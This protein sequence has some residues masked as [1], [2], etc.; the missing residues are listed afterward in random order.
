MELE[1]RHLRTLCA[2]ADTGSLTKAATVLRLSQPAL[3]ARLKRVEAEIGAPLF[4]RGPRGVIATRLGEF[5]LV[6]AR[7]I[8][9]GVA[10]LN[11]GP[12][13]YADAT[14][15]VI[16]LG[17]ALGSVSVGL[18]ER[19]SAELS[20]VEVRLT[21]EYSPRLLWDLLVAGRL[22]AVATVDYPGYELVSTSDIQCARIAAEPVYVALAET[23]PLA[24]RAE[25]GLSELAER[26]WVM[27]P[28]DGAGWPDC[29]HHACERAGFT[30][31]VLYTSPSPDSIRDLVAGRGAVTACQVVYRDGGGVVVR[32]LLGDPVRMRHV[33]AIRRSGRLAAHADTVIAA[34]TAAY[35][36][37]IELHG[38]RRDRLPASVD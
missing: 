4:H 9:H 7:T 35:W 1:L 19:I 24:G 17:G 18:A 3:T 29:F 10:D 12:D 23:D 30:P 26:T 13:R 21:M 11:I 37:Y 6:R 28:S 31:R 22:D 8:L 16:A 32:P 5:V 20:G 33:L 27:T 25:I 2:I 34:A 36:S 15:P 38:H 14:A